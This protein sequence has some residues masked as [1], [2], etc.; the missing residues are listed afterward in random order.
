MTKAGRV[1][2]HTCTF[3]RTGSGNGCGNDIN[4]KS[5]WL[6]KL[7]C[8]TQNTVDRVRARARVGQGLD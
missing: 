2:E 4:G 6:V 1:W 5:V 3:D 8:Y 7:G